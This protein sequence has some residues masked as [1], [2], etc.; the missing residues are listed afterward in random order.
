LLHGY[1]QSTQGVQM[2][3]ERSAFLPCNFPTV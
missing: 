3:E 1:G 2:V